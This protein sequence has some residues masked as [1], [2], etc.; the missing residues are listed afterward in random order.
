MIKEVDKG[1]H[2]HKMKL[3]YIQYQ[4]H[5]C[6][7]V[8]S[9]TF[10]CSLNISLARMLAFVWGLVED[11]RKHPLYYFKTFFGHCLCKH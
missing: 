5:T 3:A 4:Y 11:E 7:S 9:C 6:V 2:I 10:S 8:C 1:E